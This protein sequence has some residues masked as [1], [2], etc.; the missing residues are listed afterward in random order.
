MIITASGKNDASSILKISRRCQFIS[1]LMSARLAMPAP[2]TIQ[3]QVG[4]AMRS[5]A[6]ANADA[7]AGGLLADIGPFAFGDSE[8]QP[9]DGEAAA[10]HRAGAHARQLHR[11]R[12]IAGGALDRELA[13]PQKTSG[14]LMS[15]KRVSD[16]GSEVR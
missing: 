3:N 7:Y 11:H 12:H 14:Q 8:V 2:K 1:Q 5:A 16:S 15:F 10:G 13:D 9:L 6:A 4:A